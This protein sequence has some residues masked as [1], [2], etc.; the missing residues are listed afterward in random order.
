MKR[1]P[2]RL[3]TGA[4][5]RESHHFFLRVESEED[6]VAVVVCRKSAHAAMLFARGRRVVKRHGHI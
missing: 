1:G 3:L 5:S 4:A 6:V 2:A